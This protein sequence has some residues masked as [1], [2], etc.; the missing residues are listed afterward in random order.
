MG[1]FNVDI[2]KGGKAI[3]TRKGKARPKAANIITEEVPDAGPQAPAV[4]DAA[5]AKK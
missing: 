5:P 2:T 3:L 1:E 4:P